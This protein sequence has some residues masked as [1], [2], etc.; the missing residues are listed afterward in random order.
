MRTAGV[1]NKK[2]NELR[3][4]CNHGFNF[5]STIIHGPCTEVV[6]KSLGVASLLSSWEK[7]GLFYNFNFETATNSEAV[8]FGCPEVLYRLA[9]KN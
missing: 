7:G 9:F 8:P 5:F 2:E 6:I 4:F 3:V 1:I